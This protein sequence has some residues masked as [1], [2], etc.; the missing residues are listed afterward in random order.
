M[1]KF[2]KNLFK[3]PE[4]KSFSKEV[5]PANFKP[6][7]DPEPQKVN[8]DNIGYKILEMTE[9]ME[10]DELENLTI[11]LYKRKFNR[12]LTKDEEG[13]IN[14]CLL[15]GMALGINLVRKEF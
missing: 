13:I 9:D 7:K 5:S 8:K 4:S 6:P 15:Y 1:I 10:L 14:S 11:K 12:E 3:E 2:L